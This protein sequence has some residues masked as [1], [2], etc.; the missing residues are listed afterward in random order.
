MKTVTM[1]E[2][3]KD[4]AGYRRRVAKGERFVLSH[5]GQ[6]SARLEPIETIPLEAEAADDRFQSASAFCRLHRDEEWSFA[7]CVSFC[8]M[9]E[10]PIGYAFTTDHHFKQAGSVPLL[11]K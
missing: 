7:D 10:L 8:L 1:L 9:R 2:F 6:P 4:A 11:K 5:R 3:R